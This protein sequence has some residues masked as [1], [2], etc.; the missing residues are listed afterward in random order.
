MPGCQYFFACLLSGNLIWSLIDKDLDNQKLLSV[1][2]L[3][4]KILTQCGHN[5]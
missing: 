3:G 4:A 2:I 1:Q 5:G